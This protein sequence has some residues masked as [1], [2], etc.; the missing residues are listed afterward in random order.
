MYFAGTLGISKRDFYA[1][2]GVSRGTLESKTG[3]TEDVITKFFAAY[4]EVSIEWLMLGVGE[5]LKNC[6]SRCNSVEQVPVV[7]YHGNGLPEVNQISV[8]HNI[9][10]RPRIPLDAAAGSL[11]VALSSASES[12]CEQMPI[13]PTLPRYDFTIVARGDSMTPDILSG[14]ELACR[15]INETGFIQWGR[16]HVLDTAQGIVVKRIFDANDNIVCHSSNP[17]YPDFP[18]AKT[19]IY[20]L[21]LVVGLVRQI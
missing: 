10:T 13:I 1:K 6:I 18:V 5:M 3:I 15:F 7:E 9:T 21:A 4:P 19:E 12:A 14:D 20:H 16:T 2:I 17:N 8:P 11:S